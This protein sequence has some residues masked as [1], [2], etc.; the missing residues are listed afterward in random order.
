[1]LRAVLF[2]ALGSC[3]AL[4]EHPV[5]GGSSG[6]ESGIA[7]VV[8]GMLSSYHYAGRPVDDAVAAQ[9]VDAY[10]DGLDYGRMVFLASDVDEFRALAPAMRD[11][12]R[13]RAPTMAVAHQIHARYVE[14]TRERITAANAILAGPIDLTDDEVF[15]FDRKGAPWPATAEAANDLWRQRIEEELIRGAIRE[16]PEEA[17][18][19]LLRKRYHRLLTDVVSAEPMDVI[20]R[21]LTALS[22]VYDPH[23]AYFK[24]AT[25]DNFDIEI[26]NSLEGIGASLLTEGEYTVVK[27]LIAG[28]PAQRGGVLQKEDK[29]IAVAQGDG[30]PVDVVDLRIDKVV[31]LIRGKKGTEV[32]L[33]IIPASAVDPG[34]TRV[35][36]IVRDTVVLADS[37]AK[38]EVKEIG[39][40]KLAVI[41]VPSFY[42]DVRNKRSV[43][44]DVERILKQEMGKVD[45]V[46]LDFRRN[47]GGSLPEAVALTGL[48]IKRGPVVQIR[49]RDGSVE[50]LDDRDP[51]VAWAGPLMVLTSPVS[52]S[53]SEIVAGAIQD[54]GRGIVVGSKTTHGKGTVQT[55]IDLS[56]MMARITRNVGPQAGA[57]KLTTQKFYRITGSSTQV[58]GVEADVV[59]PSIWDGLD[60]Y[61]A[62]LDR[63]LPW[64]EIAGVSFAPLG[65]AKAA[66]PAL[67]AKSAARVAKHEG[68]AEIAEVVAER[69]RLKQSKSV[70]LVLE[71]R[72]AER[73]REL[74]E[75]A[76]APDETK[77]KP[78]DDV[79][80][81]EALAV[82][83][84]WL[85]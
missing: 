71:K 12:L 15:A 4:A 18:R 5:F 9:W 8:S 82:M 42:L 81:Q 59:I 77:P 32:R 49:E 65:D 76:E 47:G 68:F 11:D 54:Y 66:A 22:Q 85:G 25:H 69:E 34:E 67:Q 33:T 6:N 41:D 19:E 60:V 3:S 74:D 13:S 62:D 31:K 46:V 29:I 75:L 23:T 58:R 78:E 17:T 7:V 56:D 52:A 40:R 63:A 84:D 79:V 38:F 73:K 64:D 53:A 16:K 45:G 20:E 83:V 14:R 70:S 48:F 30:E 24:P 27:E 80:L 36:P 51:S 61:E 43:S 21:Y 26:S 55:V 37:N 1:M 35:V 44:S 72:L 10:L 57:L 2:L 39:G 50:S 28:G